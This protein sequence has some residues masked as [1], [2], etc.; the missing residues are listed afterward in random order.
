MPE[1]VLAVTVCT[2]IH[3]LRIKDIRITTRLKCKIDDPATICLKYLQLRQHNIAIFHR[4]KQKAIPN[5]NARSLIPIIPTKDLLD[6][7][8]LDLEVE[9]RVWWDSPG[10]KAS[11]PIG[12]IWRACQL[13]NL[14]LAHR[15]T[16]L[17]PAFDDLPKVPKQINQV[18][19]LRNR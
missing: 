1:S 11:C 5:K 6:V 16:S 7:Q 9:N 2:E 18:D 10:R 8:N 4:V 12:I 14:A 15:Q 3:V 13:R 19:I 17:V